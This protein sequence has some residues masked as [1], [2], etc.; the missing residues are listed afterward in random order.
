MI[1][2]ELYMQ[3]IRPFFGNDLIKILTGIRR[4]GKSVMLQLIQEE[5]FKQGVKKEQMIELNFESMKNAPLCTAE[6]LHQEILQR[7]SKMREKAYLFFDEIQEVLH[8]E[9]CINSLRFVGAV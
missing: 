4:S 3:R 7:I 5:L 9:K 2:R 8:W 1:Q 6:A